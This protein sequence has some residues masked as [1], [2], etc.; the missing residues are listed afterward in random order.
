ME[1]GW[2]IVAGDFARIGFEGSWEVG[3]RDESQ[4]EYPT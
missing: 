2:A 4:R 3:R 1:K